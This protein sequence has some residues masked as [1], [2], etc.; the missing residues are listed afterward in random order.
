MAAGVGSLVLSHVFVE[1]LFGLPDIKVCA[2]FTALDCINNID[3]R[4]SRSFGLGMNLG[5]GKTPHHIQNFND[6][7]NRVLHLSLAPEETTASND[8]P[9]LFVCKPTSELVETIQKRLMQDSTLPT[10]HLLQVQQMFLGTEAWLC[11]RLPSISYCGQPRRG[12][13][14]K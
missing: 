4:V 12:G 14:G 3:K 11:H 7:T 13:S 10:H 5:V 9:S 8:V 2:L 1:K 6:F